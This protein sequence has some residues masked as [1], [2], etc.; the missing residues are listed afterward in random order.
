M[1]KSKQVDLKKHASKVPVRPYTE[2]FGP[3]R[4]KRI[5]RL[6]E[7]YESFTALGFEYR[8]LVL[9]LQG[10]LKCGLMMGA[11][12]TACS[13]LELFVRDL[14]V[15]RQLRYSSSRQRE[16]KRFKALKDIESDRSASLPKMVQALRDNI[17]K[18]RDANALTKFYEQTR[19]PLQHG[20]VI[21][22]TEARGVRPI[23]GE[24]GEM[25]GSALFPSWLE[26]TIEKTALDDLDF[27]CGFIAKYRGALEPSE[28]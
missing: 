4:V 18:K 7:G 26:E 23:P 2:Q 16:R 19:I 3:R 5:T 12:Q 22:Y 10:A 27:V 11:L 24:L 6:I 28:S 25:L 17:L 20:L 8:V 1:K 14:L 21:R 9:E 13:L 15:S